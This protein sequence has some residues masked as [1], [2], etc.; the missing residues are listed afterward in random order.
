[1]HT[2]P[3]SALNFVLEADVIAPLVAL[4]RQ[5]QT[6]TAAVLLAAINV[7]AHQVVGTTDPA[8]TP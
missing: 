3:Y 7:L 4:A 8:I 1:M 2:E 5:T 6:S